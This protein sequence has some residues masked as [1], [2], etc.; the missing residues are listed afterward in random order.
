[1]DARK[2]LIPLARGRRG[3]AW[4]ATLVWRGG[5]RGMMHFHA[6]YISMWSSVQESPG[7]N[8]LMYMQYANVCANSDWLIDWLSDWGIEWS[9]ERLI[10][11][12]IDRLIDWLIDQV[13]MDYLKMDI[14]ASEWSSLRKSIDDGSLNNIKQLGIEFHFN[15]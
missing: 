15:R 2:S 13:V 5:Y 8:A 3:A 6:P 7:N 9:I 12:L 4:R 10:E 14:E 11:W 1:M